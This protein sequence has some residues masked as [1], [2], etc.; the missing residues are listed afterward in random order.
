MR[1]APSGLPPPVRGR[2]GEGGNA[3]RQAHSGIRC[4]VAV[5]PAEGGDT[6]RLI[7]SVAAAQAYGGGDFAEVRAPP[8]ARGKDSRAV[9]IGAAASALEDG[10]D[11]LLAVTDAETIVPD[12][13]V[14]VAPALRLH[15]VV[16]GAAVLV[17]PPSQTGEG[18]H[19]KHGGGGESLSAYARHLPPPPPSAVP[20]PRFAGEE[21]RA[22]HLSPSPNPS[23][24]GGGGP[25]KV[26]RITR[27]AAQDLP[28][29]FHAALRWWIG[30]T[31]FVRPA[32]ALDALS[33]ATGPAW[34][35]DYM[36]NLWKRGRAYKT[37]QA[38]TVFH[39]P[40]PQLAEAERARF[41]EAL[42][43]EP[44]FMPL[45][46]GGRTLFL[47]YTGLNPV[48]E[49]EQM[50]G[51]FFEQEE[52]NYLAERLPRGL[53]ILDVGANTG[54]HTLFFAAAME[55]QAVIPIEPHPRAAAAI[56]AV[57]ARNALANVDLSCLG[58]AAGAAEGR[59]RP[60]PVTSAGLG[61]TSFAEDSGGPVRLA[62]LD[63]L[64]AGPVD[65]MKVDVE[66]MEMAVLA[67]A[68]GLIARH[69]P[70]LFIEVL[71]ES[72]AEFAAWVDAHEYDYEKLFPDKTHC[73]YFLVP[74]ERS[75]RRD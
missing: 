25:V 36:M 15:E 2:A 5:L 75:E 9:L 27:L 63:A 40:L 1:D 67:G 53:R 34:R 14:K 28:T 30:P 64:I 39:A 4:A 44:V 6:D 13:F 68:A 26:E 69:R 32:A 3:S 31:H 65:F 37:A 46:H 59:L 19:A 55:A 29:F 16:W 21:R 61:A 50:R 49:R 7:R 12:V 58:V 74:A 57:A 47:P 66:G 51:L 62:P 43:R 54:N 22:R 8:Q 18:D 38:L 33:T 60:N 23:P 73:N 35:A 45:R 52:L 11:W 56:R 72:V 24:Q 48:I 10:F 71:D 70:Y 20:L 17:P 42:E 41:V